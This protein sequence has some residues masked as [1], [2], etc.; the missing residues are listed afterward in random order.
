MPSFSVPDRLVGWLLPLAAIV[1]EGALLAVVYVAVQTTIDHRSPLLGT[2]EF[3]AAAGI[4]A[5]AVRRGWLDPDE[6]LAPFLLLLAGL[7][8]LGWMWDASVREALLDGRWVDAIS[9]HPGGWLMVAAAMRG[10]GRGVEIDDRAVTR[11][12]LVGV[13]LLAIPWAL[14]Q[15]AAGDL[16]D[17]FTEAAYVASMTFVT[18]GFIA[19]GLARLQEIGRET[20]VDWRRNRSWLGTVLGVLVVV[21]ALGVPAALILGLPGSAVARG[22]L[23]PLLSMLGYAF[24]FVAGLAALLAAIIAGMLRSLGVELPPPMTPEEIA[25]LPEIAEVTFEQVRGALTALAVF[26]IALLV[27]SVVLLRVW[28]RRRGR[29]S[30]RGATEERS[31]SIPERSFRLRVPRLP[32]APP[33]PR[34]TTPR[35]AVGAYLAALDDLADRDAI[36]AR[37]EHETPRAH[38]RRIGAGAELVALQA[39]YALARYGG[40]GLTEPEHRRAIGRWRRLRER[41]TR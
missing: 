33:R 35:D 30:L 38:A 34:R 5:L 7:G 9:L 20:G 26:W 21:L 36:H 29:R 39:D 3:A 37:A 16:R 6:Q 17:E 19:A 11:L 10:V 41:L 15:V 32:P 27:V 12:V 23:D 13:P 22:I 8:A 31:I 18:S 25:Q 40:R 24:V 2:L 1:A 28:L 14:G 4:A